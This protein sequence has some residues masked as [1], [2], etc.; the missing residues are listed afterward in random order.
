MGY[1]N[2]IS[3]EIDQNVISGIFPTLPTCMMQVEEPTSRMYWRVRIRS[4]SKVA[5]GIIEHITSYFIRINLNMHFE[6]F[7]TMNY[8]IIYH[9]KV[10]TRCTFEIVESVSGVDLSALKSYSWFYLQQ[11]KVLKL[12]SSQS[13]PEAYIFKSYLFTACSDC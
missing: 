10:F 6:I 3:V 9:T 4:E 8:Y 12:V 5:M 1:D 11:S 13:L 2:T 7:S